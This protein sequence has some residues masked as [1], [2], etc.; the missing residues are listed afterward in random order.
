M[1]HLEKLTHLIRIRSKEKTFAEMHWL[2]LVL[3]GG[4]SFIVASYW[5]LALSSIVPELLEATNKFGLPPLAIGLWLLVGGYA[6][7]VWY[8]GCIASRCHTVL[9]ERW[10]K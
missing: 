4:T 7:A 6:I 5:A 3:F 2:I 10:F 8:F 1:K 9:Y